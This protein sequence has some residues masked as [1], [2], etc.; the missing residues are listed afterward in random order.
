MSKPKFDIPPE[1]RDSLRYVESQDP[2]SDAE[3]LASLHPYKPI[4]TEK[5]IWAFWDRGA[6]AMPAWC[7]RNVANWSRLLG[8]SW[9]IRILDNV[10][11][12]PSHA[13]NYL[14]EDLLPPTFIKGTMSGEYV[15]QHSADF[16]RGACLW[17]YGGV[18][19]DVG[20][21]LV[22]HVDKICW[23]VLEDERRMEEVAVPGMYGNTIANHFV[24]SR[25]GSVFI[26]AW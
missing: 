16:L 23:D 12:S 10:P 2:R 26:K 13:L 6:D 11:Y 5:N 19:M 3:I 7:K 17:L 4:T 22:R 15:G 8:P 25:K 18:F 20:I 24:A 9:T 1:L 21:I 14:P